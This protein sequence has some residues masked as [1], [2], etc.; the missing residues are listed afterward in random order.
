M[1]VARP[2]PHWGHGQ[3]HSAVLGRE[4]WVW[5]PFKIQVSG[6]HR[7]GLC[8][9]RAERLLKTQRTWR[10]QK[11][12]NAGHETALAANE[13]RIRNLGEERSAGK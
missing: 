5:D 1:C 9:P 3:T 7:R 4:Q 10:R 8:L 13:K 12:K 6:G 11:V 2:R